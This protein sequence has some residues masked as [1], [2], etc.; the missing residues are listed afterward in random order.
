MDAHL[1]MASCS[2]SNREPTKSLYTC[3][4]QAHNQ[5]M[6]CYGLCPDDPNLQLQRQNTEQHMAASCRAALEFPEDVATSITPVELA[7]SIPV[8]AFSVRAS[9]G[10]ATTTAVRGTTT[11]QILDDAAQSSQVTRRP[12][13]DRPVFANDATMM[14]FSLML[15]F[16]SIT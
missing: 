9:Y 11:P 15:I 13:S 7:T 3:L 12:T 14:A 5:L 6:G 8:S 2:E 10:T 16:I 1:Q 4:C